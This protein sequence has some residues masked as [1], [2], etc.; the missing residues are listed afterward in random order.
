MSQR[1]WFVYNCSPS[2]EQS[3]NCFQHVD[4]LPVCTTN[5]ELICAIYGI[6]DPETYGAHPVPLSV[7]TKL[8]DYIINALAAD[9]AYPP[10]PFKPYVYV[11][12]T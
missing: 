3:W 4:F 10:P 2:N 6:Y 9:T 5:G 8:S 1:A 11:K 12:L 7:D